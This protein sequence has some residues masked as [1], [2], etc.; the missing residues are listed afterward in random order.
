M[1]KQCVLKAVSDRFLLK[2]QR[3][4]CWEHCVQDSI[5]KVTA[6]KSPHTNDV[7]FILPN[8]LW[9]QQ[10]SYSHCYADP[11]LD[12]V[13]F[14]Q[15]SG[16]DDDNDSYAYWM[17]P[18]CRVPGTCAYT[19]PL[20]STLHLSVSHYCLQPGLP[21]P[22]LASPFSFLLFMTHSAHSS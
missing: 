12:P 14:Y 8:F 22:L 19:Q 7:W 11:L 2:M 6:I 5:Q 3:E 1:T 13:A 17:F 20:L 15:A 10:C 4:K 21:E 16:K 18:M 9:T